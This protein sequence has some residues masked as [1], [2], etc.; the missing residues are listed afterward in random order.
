M[1]RRRRQARV[2]DGVTHSVGTVART[3]A[4]AVR[5]GAGV[6]MPSMRSADGGLE[7]RGEEG[8]TGEG[9]RHARSDSGNIWEGE[10]APVA[11]GTV[12]VDEDGRDVSAIFGAIRSAQ[13]R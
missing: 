13:V 11:R 2:R 8:G 4:W 5:G 6:V 1:L 10:T 12:L 9:Q 7:G 3:G